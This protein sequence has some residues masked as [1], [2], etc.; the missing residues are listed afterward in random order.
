MQPAEDWDRCDAADLLLAPELWSILP[1]QQMRPRFFVVM[2]SLPSWP[3]QR[4][5]RKLSAGSIRQA[6]LGTL[7]ERGE[8][9]PIANLLLP[10]K[11]WSLSPPTR[12]ATVDFTVTARSN[13]NHHLASDF[14][15]YMIVKMKPFGPIRGWPEAGSTN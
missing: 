11:N 15:W 7:F 12:G 5:Y 14:R 10:L 1:E 9:H 4:P 8:V 2:T 3:V 13:S 6:T